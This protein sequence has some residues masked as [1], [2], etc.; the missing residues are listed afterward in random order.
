MCLLF[1][2]TMTMTKTTKIT[3]PY[4]RGPWRKDSFPY[5]EIW[6]APLLVSPFSG[7]SLSLPNDN[8]LLPPALFGPIFRL[9]ARTISH[10]GWLAVRT[11]I[12]QSDRVAQTTPLAI[13]H[14]KLMA[15][16]PEG[17][18]EPSSSTVNNEQSAGQ[19]STGLTRRFPWTFILHDM[20]KQAN[21]QLNTKQEVWK[22][23]EN[24]GETINIG[25]T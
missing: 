23:N 14:Q 16:W 9:A 1:R 3:F 7:I 25:T 5:C 21:R 13:K 22:F 17:G 2:A 15:K 19:W 18:C 12:S 6:L 24:I 20:T 4:R 10:F 8:W 11:N